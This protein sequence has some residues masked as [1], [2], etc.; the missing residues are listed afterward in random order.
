V[1]ISDQDEDGEPVKKTFVF[2]VYHNKRYQEDYEY[3][4]RALRRLSTYASDN[5]VK[6]Y[7]SFRQLGSYCL[8]L[9]YV[10]GGSLGEF[11]DN[12]PAPSTPEDVALF[13]K[14]L[15]QTFSGLHRI[16]QPMAYDDD[17]VT[18]VIHEDIEPG[19]IL[20]MRGSSGSFYDFTP[21]ITDFGLYSRVRTAKARA[22]DSMALDLDAI[23]SFSKISISRS[24][25][26]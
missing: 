1:L 14:S 8:I 20:L 22:D 19:N 2:K 6:F 24:F 18:K 17:E 4:L 21:K 16:H 23:R 3:E 25:L 10:D 26:S 12:S 9:E 13:W 5:I 15:F 11:F 7:G